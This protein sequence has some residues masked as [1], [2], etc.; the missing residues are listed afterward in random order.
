MANDAIS[1]VLNRL[2]ASLSETV[3]SMLDLLVATADQSSAPHY[4]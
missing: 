4:S 3:R 1:A 2:G